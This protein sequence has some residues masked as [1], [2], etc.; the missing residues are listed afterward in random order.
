VTL[1]TDTHTCARCEGEGTTLVDRDRCDGGDCPGRTDPTTGDCTRCGYS[2]DG[3][4][5]TP[6]DNGPQEAAH[7]ME[8]ARRPK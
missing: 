3:P 1:Y 2:Y 4:Y 5:E 8:Q 6:T 7:R